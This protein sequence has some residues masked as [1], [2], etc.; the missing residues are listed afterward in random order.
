MQPVHRNGFY[1]SVRDVNFYTKTILTLRPTI[2]E[3]SRY[4]TLPLVDE[5]QTIIYYS[6]ILAFAISFTIISHL[7]RYTNL[8]F[9]LWYR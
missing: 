5:L 1:T 2:V 3:Y 6:R 9:H 4:P 7:S 8:T